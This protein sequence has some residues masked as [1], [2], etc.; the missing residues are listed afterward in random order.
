MVPQ[1]RVLGVDV[2]RVIT[3]E[4]LETGA[5]LVTED[6]E[7]APE[8]EGAFS[9]LKLLNSPIRFD[10]R[11]YLVSKCG[12]KVQERTR[13]WLAHRD[14][15]TTTGIDPSK[16]HFVRERN[17][18]AAV[19]RHLGVTD[20][21]DDRIGVL[22]SLDWMAGRFLFKP[23]NP[24]QLPPWVV[25]VRSWVELERHLRELKPLARSRQ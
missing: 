13:L 23:E 3:G 25:H 15:Y 11:V 14:F 1:L 22:Q 7:K 18:K 10:G 8:V 12:P 2:G 24:P 21:V 16:L 19:C 5:P 20:F 4:D 9:C 17:Q 6:W